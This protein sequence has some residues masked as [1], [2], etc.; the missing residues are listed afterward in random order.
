MLASFFSSLRNGSVDLDSSRE[1]RSL[2]AIMVVRKCARYAEF[3]SSAGRNVALERSTASVHSNDTH[4]VQCLSRESH[5]E[6]TVIAADALEHWL[7]TFDTQDRQVIEGI[8][9]GD[10]TCEIAERL[11]CSQRT[12]QRTLQRVFR[13]LG[14]T[15]E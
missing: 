1:L 5:P 2:L 7:L 9:A 3:F 4:P 10:S 13:A 11:I 8:L 12:V 14:V 6:E 15:Q